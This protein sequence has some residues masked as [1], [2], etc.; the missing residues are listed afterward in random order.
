MNITYQSGQW[1]ALVNEQAI[2]VLAPD[3]TIDAIEGVWASLQQEVTLGSVVDGLTRG[4]G[5]RFSQIPPFAALVRDGAGVRLAVRG[6]IVAHVSSLAGTE[7]FTGAEVTTWSE[8][9]VADLTGFEIVLDEEDADGPGLPI[10][11]GAVRV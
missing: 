6:Q 5:G 2:V 4:H 9:F 3:A 8:R 11:S 10:G 7:S 1:Y